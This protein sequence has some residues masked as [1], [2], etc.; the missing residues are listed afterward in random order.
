MMNDV[1]DGSNPGCGTRGF[2]A[3]IGWDP[4]TGLGTPNYGM[5][6]AALGQ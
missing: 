4:V 6:S 2:P 5:M 3:K 1:T